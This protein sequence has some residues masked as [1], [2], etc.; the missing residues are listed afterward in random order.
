[1]LSGRS[2]EPAALFDSILL[3]QQE[4]RDIFYRGRRLSHREHLEY[5]PHPLADLQAAGDIHALHRLIERF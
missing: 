3:F 1:M 4:T 2:E 5:M